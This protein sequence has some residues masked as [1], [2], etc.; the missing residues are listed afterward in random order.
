MILRGHPVVERLAGRLARLYGA[1]RAEAGLE[2]LLMMI[3]RYGLEPRPARPWTQRDA[4]LIAYAD[5]VARPATRPLAVL[6]QFADRRLRD[7]FSMVHLLPFCPSSSDDGF[8]VVHY[9]AP[10]PALG[11]W[12]DVR[13]LGE[14]FDLAFDLVLNHVSARSGW[15]LDYL[16]GTAPGRHYFIEVD[17]AADLS[18]V[19]RPRASPLTMPVPT[20]DGRR[21]V[22]TT[23]S[24]DQ[25]DLNYA[26]P[27]VLFEILDILLFYAAQGTSLIRLDAVAYLWKTIGTDCIHR[28]ETH[29]LV[30]L[31]RDVLA[32]AA[33]GV[34]LLAEVNAPHAENVAYFGAGDEA[35]LVY[36][37]ALPPLLLHALLT[38][39]AGP[40][41]R[42]ARALEDPPPGCAFLNFT[43]SH[44]GIGLR[45]AEDCLPPDAARALCDAARRRG[46]RVST[47]RAPDGSERPYELNIA[48]FDALSGA[49]PYGSARHVARF[50]CSQAV[51]L[52]LKGI[53]AVYFHSLTATP[54]DRAAV[55]QT[56]QARA[57]NRRRWRED[58]LEA[59]L[60]DPA[61]PGSRVFRAYR[62]LLR[63]RAR[64]PAFHPDGAQRVLDLGPRGFGLERTAP[65]GG[66]RVWCL[67]NC[68]DQPLELPV[69]GA[70]P[71]AG[72]CR[73]LIRGR[74]L[75]GGRSLLLEPYQTLW[76]DA[77]RGASTHASNPAEPDA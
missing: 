38:G 27:D 44:D 58:D 39:E 54:N 76:L 30:R 32:L 20:R 12:A 4:I 8:A 57:I 31:F 45:P 60:A 34:R 19:V 1:A 6:K 72:A 64:H 48:W 56:G 26:H 51:A 3:G 50:L 66:A 23:F 15:F 46:G 47:R 2:R 59:W 73:D 25:V 53:P 10:D 36:Q 28:P 65:G 13:A 55:E 75:A 77:A 74:R 24:P 16:T 22:W 41:S 14:R 33:P 5:M 67:S 29:E 52:A 71:P 63:T 70:L 18:A 68:S 9:R 17:P 69:G 11:D 62:R 7:L 21:H 61:T 43:A 37:F 35:H 49:E 42:W 40:L